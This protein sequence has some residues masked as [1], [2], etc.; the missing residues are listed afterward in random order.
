MQR[1]AKGEVRVERDDRLLDFGK[2]RAHN[3]HLQDGLG[4][5]ERCE[6]CQK[7]LEGAMAA[8]TEVEPDVEGDEVVS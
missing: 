4:Y 3:A 7:G 2:V 1:E 6:M 8:V 5:S